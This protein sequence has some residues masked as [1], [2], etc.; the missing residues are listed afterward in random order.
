M[1]NWC[2]TGFRHEEIDPRQF[3]VD[4]ARVASNIERLMQTGSQR[5]KVQP[6]EDGILINF[7]GLRG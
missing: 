4:A 2:C 5:V 6:T 1:N 3:A 7:D